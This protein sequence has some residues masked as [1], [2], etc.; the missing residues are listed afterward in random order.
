[1]GLGSFAILSRWL[2]PHDYGLFGMAATVS[3]FVGVIGDA[4]VSSAI[5]RLPQIDAVAEATA[6]WL[7]LAGAGILTLLC[8]VAAPLIGWFYREPSITLP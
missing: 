8:G 5:I 7:S 1:M 6:F 4:G 3:A 2:T